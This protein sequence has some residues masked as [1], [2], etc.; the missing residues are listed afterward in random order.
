MI[1]R[2]RQAPVR[3][4][5]G[6]RQRRHS[7]MNWSRAAVRSP[8]KTKIPIHPFLDGNGRIGRLLITA[9]LE[10]WSLLKEPLLYLSGYLKRNQTEYY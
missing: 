2:G 6:W 1:G 8:K 5:S 7:G 4:G 3:L 10:L 9:L